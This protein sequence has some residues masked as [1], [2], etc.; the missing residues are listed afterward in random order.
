MFQTQY[1]PAG[2]RQ[3]DAKANFFRYESCNSNGADESI[4]VKADGN[5][6][7]LFLPGDYVDLPIYATRWEV[8]PTNA[9]VMGTVRLGAG[10]VG[11]SR[12]TGTVKVIDQ[13]IDKTIYGNQFFGGSTNIADATNQVA[14]SLRISAAGIAAGK[15]I[16]I[17]NISFVTP[18]S[19]DFILNIGTA[20]GSSTNGSA[21]YPGHNKL[22]FGPPPVGIV[23]AAL[24][25]PSTLLAAGEM[26]GGLQIGARLAAVA[27]TTLQIGF[28]EPI[29]ISG[30]QV[31][32]VLGIVANRQI[33]AG[34]EWEEF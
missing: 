15:K 25:A 16:A 12:L 13:S 2:G 21:P 14:V 19:G 34:F 29:V 7:G 4:R 23:H 27:A 18:L 8:V 31:F 6:M 11:S 33:G 26:S 32:A 1:F 24:A 28:K 10:K 17:K 5:D 9:A 3:I 22:A 30:S 20:P